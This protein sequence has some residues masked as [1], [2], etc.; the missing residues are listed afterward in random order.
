[1]KYLYLI[2]YTPKKIIVKFS[3]K[4]YG[5]V[6]ER[7]KHK[8]NSYSE[9]EAHLQD[10]EVYEMCKYMNLFDDTITEKGDKPDYLLYK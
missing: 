2:D 4:K 9:L 5:K 3:V 7:K 8:F 6:K 10:L 1:M